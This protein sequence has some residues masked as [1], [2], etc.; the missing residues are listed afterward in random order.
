MSDGVV[1]V[2]V[3]G[4][5]LIYLLPSV[6]AWIR[7]HRQRGPIIVVNVLLGWTLLGLCGSPCMVGLRPWQ[8]GRGTRAVIKCGRVPRFFV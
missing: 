3:V 2:V 1:V 6:I 8:G 4:G 7:V 5:L